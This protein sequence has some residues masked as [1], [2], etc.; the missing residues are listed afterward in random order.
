[1]RIVNISFGRFPEISYLNPR[2]KP[3]SLKLKLVLDVFLPKEKK[4][5]SF[6]QL[7]GKLKKILPTLDKHKCCVGLLYGSFS[8]SNE[9]DAPIKQVG[10]VTDIAHLIEHMIIDLEASVSHMPTCSGITCGYKR[11]EVRFDLFIECKDR[12]V[13]RF[14]SNFSVFLMNHLFSGKSLSPRYFDLVS[15]AKYLY[16]DRSLI[17]C[18]EK[19]ASDLGWKVSYTRKRIKEL[20]NF[21]YLTKDELN[22][23]DSVKEAKNE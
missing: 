22:P 13:A 23:S 4:S 3:R 18:P 19:I 2:F 8:Y 11:P 21:K 16:K 12:S 1:M 20:L 9:S 10:G 15:L 6:P 7:Y 17:L 14:A 5:I